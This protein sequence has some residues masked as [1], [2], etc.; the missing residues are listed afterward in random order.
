MAVAA[1]AASTA[2]SVGDIR[3]ATTEQALAC[4]FVVQ[5]LVLLQAVNRAGRLTLAA[6]SQTTLVSGLQS[7]ASM[8]TFLS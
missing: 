7:A 8:R 5:L 3:R 4:G 2:F 1:W 6:Q